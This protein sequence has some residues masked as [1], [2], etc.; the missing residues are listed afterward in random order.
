MAIVA[1]NCTERGPRTQG[2]FLDK[3]ENALH[4]SAVHAGSGTPIEEALTDLPSLAE[5]ADRKPLAGNE[6]VDLGVPL[7]PFTPL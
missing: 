7:Q 3:Q 6:M 4:T 2:Q 1:V 5:G